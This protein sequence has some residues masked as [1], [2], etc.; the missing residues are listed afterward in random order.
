MASEKYRILLGNCEVKINEDIYTPIVPP[1]I[2]WDMTSVT[3]DST[4]ITFDSL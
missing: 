4:E 3:W 2:T 1:P